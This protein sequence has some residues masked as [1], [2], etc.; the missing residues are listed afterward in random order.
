M[1]LLHHDI[2]HK[3]DAEVVM[4]TAFRLHLKQAMIDQFAKQYHAENEVRLGVG[5]KGHGLQQLR[6]GVVV[7]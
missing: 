5:S 7:G 3:V 4:D 6:L 1:E 2:P